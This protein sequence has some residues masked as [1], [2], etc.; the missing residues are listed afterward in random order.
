M[1]E[2]DF[3]PNANSERKKIDQS[4]EKLDHYATMGLAGGLSFV[5]IVSEAV[6]CVV[7]PFCR[8]KKNKQE[9]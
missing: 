2:D 8:E 7:K 1:E 4:A 5:E 6:C 9:S 3:V